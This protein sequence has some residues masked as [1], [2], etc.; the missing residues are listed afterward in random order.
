LL[1][2]VGE[3]GLAAWKV[4]REGKKVELIQH[5][6]IVLAGLVD[7][8]VHPSGEKA[9]VLDRKGRLHLIGLGEG[10]RPQ[11][12]PVR[13]RVEVRSL[14]GDAGGRRFTFVSPDGKLATCSWS[15]A[16]AGRGRVTHQM[17]S[18]VSLSG[19]GRWA[20]TAVP[21]MGIIIY[22]LA[23]GREWLH[24]PPDGSGDIWGLAWSPDGA[25]LAVGLSDGGVAIWELEAVRACLAELGIRIE[26]TCSLKED[27]VTR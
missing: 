8:V 6:H 3:G 22:D 14:H 1:V 19:A 16:A 4:R 26:S 21:G 7:L 11:L 17:A 5:R 23:A 24:L 15:E 20:A 27:K 10:A 13:A 9:V 18:V 12:L 25:R 2:G